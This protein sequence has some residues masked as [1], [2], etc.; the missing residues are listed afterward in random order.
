M[1][2]PDPFNRVR[3]WWDRQ[4]PG[5]A[6]L[7]AD[8]TRHDYAPHSHDAFVIAMTEAGGSEFKSRG[9]IEE[10]S[11][12]RLLVFNPAEP[13]SGRM[14]RSSRWRYRSFYLD[15]RAVAAVTAG[16]G[17]A[18]TPYF[19]SNVFADPDLVAAFLAL[20]RAR[21]EGNDSL[22]QSELL[23]ASFGKLVARHAAE[24]KRMPAAPSDRRLLHRVTAI[25]RARHTESLTLEDLG[26]DVGLTAFQLIGLFKRAAGITPHAYLTQVR[27]DAAT[28]SLRAGE[29]I[30]QAAIAAGFYDQAALTTHFKRAYGITPRQFVRAE[31]G[32]KDE[33]GNFGQ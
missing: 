25:M 15:E 1:A 22:R 21:D 6:L 12:T 8:F 28:R 31:A 27:L 18:A 19:T 13:H 24:G 23:A 7:E 14:A 5:L 26:Q 3:Y 20:H 17:I 33:P 2:K 9:R 11:A 30:A 29:P 4:I 10:A 32:E 16:L